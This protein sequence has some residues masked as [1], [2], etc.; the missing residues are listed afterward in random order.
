M[1]TLD[2]TPLVEPV[3]A[4]A[5][6]TIAGL[7]TVYVPKALAVFTEATGI[8]LTEQQRAAFLGAVQTAKGVIETKLDQNALSVAHVDVNNEAIRAEAAAAI[9]AVPQAA[10]AFGLTEDG[11]AR[12][13]VGAVDTALHGNRMP[14]APATPRPPSAPLNR[15]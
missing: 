2:I 10:A 13:I 14:A 7:L 3:L 12:M 11:V 1:S 9:A 8:A 5:G 4:V 6:A 15:P